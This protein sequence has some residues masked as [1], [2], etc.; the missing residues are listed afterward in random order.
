MAAAHQRFKN[1]AG[2][3]CRGLGKTSHCHNQPAAPERATVVGLDLNPPVH[4]Q[5]AGSAKPRHRGNTQIFGAAKQGP[6]DRSSIVRF[7][8]IIPARIALQGNA[9]FSKPGNRLFLPKGPENW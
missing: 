9:E 3:A 8:E 5:D 7:R 6:E 1:A 2:T 4:G